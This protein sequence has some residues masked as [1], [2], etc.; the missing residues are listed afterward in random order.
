MSKSHPHSD[1]VSGPASIDKA[2]NVIDLPGNKLNP[3]L[4]AGNSSTPDNFDV[5]V[6][7]ERPL[8][9]AQAVLSN[10]LKS[11]LHQQGRVEKIRSSL[12]IAGEQIPTLDQTSLSMLQEAYI[13]AAT[14]C[15]VAADK[16][17]IW[18][19]RVNVL[20]AE[21]YSDVQLLDED[22]GVNDLL[23]A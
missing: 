4:V 1:S 5:D 11:Q 10:A 20:L 13:N 17:V 2:D 22:N 18:Q 19:Q 9:A 3:V 8:A 15:S 12:L 16:A 7:K 6:T 14:A 21:Q 23:A